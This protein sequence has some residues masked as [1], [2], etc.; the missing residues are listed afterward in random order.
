M[1][2]SGLFAFFMDGKNVLGCAIGLHPYLSFTVATACDESC[3]H[4]KACFILHAELVLADLVEEEPLDPFDLDCVRETSRDNEQ[5]LSFFSQIVI[6]AKSTSRSTWQPLYS[7]SSSGRDLCRSNHKG[8]QS[9][10]IN[11]MRRAAQA[12]LFGLQA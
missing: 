11:P 1:F 6:A 5:S 7:C 8:P 12:N 2:K 10:C 4:M 3:A 9:R